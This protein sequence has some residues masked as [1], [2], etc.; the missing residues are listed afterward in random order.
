MLTVI[1]VTSACPRV[2]VLNNYFT[3]LTPEDGCEAQQPKR[4]D[5]PLHQD[6]DKSPKIP[7]QNINIPSSK[8]LRK[9][10]QIRFIRILIFG[11]GLCTII[12]FFNSCAMDDVSPTQDS[13]WHD[14]REHCCGPPNIYLSD[15]QGSTDPSF[16]TIALGCFNY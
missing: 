13:Q 7:P 4:S 14:H 9:T 10:K 2:M 1:Q 6:E 11:T 5:I 8:N 12:M 3:H 16:K 15:I